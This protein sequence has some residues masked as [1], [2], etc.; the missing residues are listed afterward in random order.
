MGLVT[1]K[2]Y[3]TLFLFAHFLIVTPKVIDMAF[4]AERHV[5]A[6]EKGRAN[7]LQEK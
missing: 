5:E 7:N 3:A 4:F 1:L 6:V 2:G